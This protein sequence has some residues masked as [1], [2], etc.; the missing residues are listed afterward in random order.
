MN[1]YIRIGELPPDEKSKRYQWNEDHTARAPVGEEKGVSAYRT[2]IV[3]SKYYV[4]IPDNPSALDTWQTLMVE[5]ENFRKRVFLITGDVINIGYDGEPVLK[6]VKVIEDID[7]TDNK[8]IIW[9]RE[10][11]TKK[12]K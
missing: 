9:K 4:Y 11:F 3:D 5:L 8:T 7:I 1:Y 6:N 10:N 2:E 12:K